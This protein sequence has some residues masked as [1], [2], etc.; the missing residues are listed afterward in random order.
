MA[1]RAACCMPG[2]ANV[3]HHVSATFYDPE[4]EPI[5]SEWL[6]LSEAERLRVVMNFHAATRTRT[7]DLKG[8]AVVHVVVENQ[9][10]IGFGPSCR[11]VT[12]L[13]GE[14]L[15]RHDAIHAIASV[16]LQCLRENPF[17]AESV[18]AKMMQTRMNDKIN[19]L[20]AATESG[21]TNA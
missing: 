9:I 3:R 2:S 7:P 6:A 17:G 5:A 14:G 1:L 4:R 21:A 16:V 11:A 19:A 8:H 13:Q 12:R 15:T 20:S 18:S 10:A